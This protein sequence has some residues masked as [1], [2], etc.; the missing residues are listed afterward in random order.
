MWPDASQQL[1]YIR[2]RQTALMTEAAASRLSAR[3]KTSRRHRFAG[4]RVRFGGAL[5]AIG[6]TLCEEDAL[7]RH[8]ARS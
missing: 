3:R 6:R 8:P 1:H 4:L 2:Q 7:R 5:I